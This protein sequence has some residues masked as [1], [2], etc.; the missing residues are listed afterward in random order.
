[1]AISVADAKKRET[2][3]RRIAKIIESISAN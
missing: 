2:R 1:M 3:D